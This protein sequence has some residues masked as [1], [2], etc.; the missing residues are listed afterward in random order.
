MNTENN[1]IHIEGFWEKK[2]NEPI[3]NEQKWDNQEKF[4]KKLSI[5]EQILRNKHNEKNNYRTIDSDINVSFFESSLKLPSK[6]YYIK[7]KGKEYW[8]LDSFLDY[9]IKQYNVKPSEKFIKFINEFSKWLLAN[10]KICD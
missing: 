5:I 2:I 7:F 8:W 6:A 3:S 10:G 4:E 9:Y 1:K